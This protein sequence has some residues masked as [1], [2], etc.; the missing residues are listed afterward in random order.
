VDS[1]LINIGGHGLGDCL[2]SLQISY[3]LSKLNIK[4][5]N[6]ISTRQQIYQPLWHI[7]GSKF[8]IEKI[9]ESYTE[10][11]ALIKNSKLL[12]EIKNKFKSNNITYNVPDLLFHHPLAFRYQDYGLNPQLIKKTRILTDHFL[13]KKEKIIY[14]G[15][16]TSTNGY[17][18]QNIPSLLRS[19]AEFLPEYTIYFP[20]I[21]HWDKPIENLGNF[22]IEFPS[23]VHIDVNPR[24]E[25]SLDILTQSSYGIFTCNGPSHVAFHLG[26]PRLILDPQFN[27]LPWITRWKEDYEECIPINLDKDTVSKIVF[28]NIRHPETL[29]FDRKFLIN[30]IEQG[31]TN[32]NNILYFKF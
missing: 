2:L 10:D 30:L 5:T 21:D 28:H 24:F 7:F 19:L 18:Y 27:K 22:S 3:H 20:Y 9:E 13:N 31:Q 11:N 8:D 1:T 4:H 17:V 25:K 23:N 29:M 26:I 16:A 12:D 14:C 6:L 15:L 32:W